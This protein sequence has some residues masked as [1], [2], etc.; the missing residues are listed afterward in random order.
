M[1]HKLIGTFVLTSSLLIIAVQ[2]Y[3]QGSS[4]STDVVAVKASRAKSSRTQKQKQGLRLL[5]SAVRG[6]F[7]LQPEMRAY[8]QWHAS[9]GYEKYNPKK[10]R[11][12]LESA[13]S[14]GTE[15][16]VTGARLK[17]RLDCYDNEPCRV[18][19]FLQ[20]GILSSMLTLAP[21][22]AW[23][24]LPQTDAV[25]RREL[26]ETL[27][28][29]Y[30]RKKQLDQAKEL[31]LRAF[32][33]GGY[34]Y[35]EAG[36]LMEAFPASLYNDRISI[37]SQALQNFQQFDTDL[38]PDQNGFLALLMHFWR[39]LPR[40][41]ALDSIDAVLSKAKEQDKSGPQSDPT[42][43]T[44]SRKGTLSFES[45]YELRLFELIPILETLDPGRAEGLLSDNP[46]VQKQLHE[47]PDLFVQ[48]GSAKEA[49]PNDSADLPEIIQAGPL[50]DPTSIGDLQRALSQVTRIDDEVL[51]DPKQ[52]LAD[53]SRLPETSVGSRNPRI[54]AFVQIARRTWKSDPATCKS[55]LAE[56][57]KQAA[58][59]RV[60]EA[61]Q[62]LLEAADL[63]DRMSASSE[64]LDTIQE[65]LKMADRLYNL[66]SDPGDPNLA[67][68]G[69]W[70]S[71]QVYGR[72]L[73][74]VARVAPRLVEEI[75]SRVQD[76]DISS[77]EI[78]TYA[79][80]LLGVPQSRLDIV[81]RHKRDNSAETTLR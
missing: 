44:T 68:K 51:R 27:L 28:S 70:P 24:L 11:A 71:T 56:V 1:S 42:V 7:S 76:P 3:S 45:T 78:V 66:D 41:I 60:V 6:T 8:V 20:T 74:L 69:N 35:Y 18:K 58:S 19:E 36:S 73:I 81:E 33:E 31:L 17:E 46:K 49:S 47:Y 48:G 63:Y 75:F 40:G 38:T 72:C 54:A 57:R 4:K 55:A 61:A 29:H 2:A 25:T 9:R 10:A 80:S 67:F 12:L 14:A 34:P 21:E 32:G 39:E 64:L 15:I 77:Y 16:S 37:F 26:T 23:E 62:L 43:I 59:L 22:K 50:H 53:A 30:I 5:D 79:D 52:A 65:V 13:F